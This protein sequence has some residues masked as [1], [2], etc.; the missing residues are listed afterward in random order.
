MKSAAP[1]TAVLI[2]AMAKR[3]A[4][5]NIGQVGKKGRAQG[6]ASPTGRCMS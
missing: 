5:R 4:D 2:Y 3:R 6:P 1:Y